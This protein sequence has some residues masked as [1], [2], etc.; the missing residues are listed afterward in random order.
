ME[1]VD[2]VQIRTNTQSEM[3]G[4]LHSRSQVFHS[5]YFRSCA[6]YSPVTILTKAF[7]QAVMEGYVWMQKVQARFDS[8]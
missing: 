6:R 8:V 3:S 1:A 5:V 4:V 2:P 7:V